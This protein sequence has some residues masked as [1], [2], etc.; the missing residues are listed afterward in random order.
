MVAWLQWAD[1]E[2]SL[3]RPPC[4]Q[5]DIFV[6][7]RDHGHPGRCPC[8]PHQ[9]A[10]PVRTSWC[11]P[12][13]VICGADS[14]VAIAL[15][16]WLNE[17]WPRTFPGLPNGIPSHDM[18]GRVFAR[19]DEARFEEGF[20]DRVQA[21][22]KPTGGRVV[23]V[24]GKSVRGSHDRGRGLSPCTWR[25]SGPRPNDWCRHRSTSQLSRPV[26]CLAALKACDVPA[27]ADYADEG[28]RGTI[29]PSR[30]PPCRNS[31]RAGSIPVGGTDSFSLLRTF[32]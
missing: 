10:S 8:R 22:F 4:E 9:A 3:Q 7:G 31:G 13:R 18:S 26:S 19:L 11:C 29:L 17:E 2:F 21:A 30:P 12:Y 32:T 25:V 6:P 15:F 28:S 27:A 20:R 24:A 14:F 16:G 1:S 23:P 5:P